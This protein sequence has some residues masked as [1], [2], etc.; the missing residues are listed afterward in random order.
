[1]G[2]TLISYDGD[3]STKTANPT[4]VKC[5]LNSVISTDDGRF[6]TGDL[7]GFYLGTDLDKFEYARIPIHLIPHHIIKLYYLKDKIINGHVYAEARKGVYGLPQAGRLANECLTK[8]LAHLG[9]IPGAHTHGFW[10]DTKSDLM[11]TLVIDDFGVR[12]TNKADAARLMHDLK[13][14]YKVSEDWEG[15]R[16]IGLTIKWD[17]DLCTVEISMPGYV[18]RALHRFSHPKPTRPQDSPHPW[19]APHYGAK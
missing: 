15:N 7:K 13:Q 1:M 5:M 10:K 2:G 9:Y 12:Y 17:Y 8:Y 19:N 11:F 16:Y 4:T 3:V 14:Q 18:E 6:M